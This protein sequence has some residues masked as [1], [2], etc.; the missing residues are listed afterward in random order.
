MEVKISAKKKSAN[1][2]ACFNEKQKTVRS[3]SSI[4]SSSSTMLKASIHTVQSKAKCKVL[5]QTSSLTNLSK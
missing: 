2:I 3:Y 1:D 4:V 5:A